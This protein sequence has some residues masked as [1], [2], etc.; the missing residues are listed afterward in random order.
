[1][2][3]PKIATNAWMREKAHASTGARHAR[4]SAFLPL[5]C[6]FLADTPAWGQEGELNSNFLRHGGR[7][8][9]EGGRLSH[10][11]QNN[12]KDFSQWNHMV[13]EKKMETR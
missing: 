5:F 3:G 10:F 6:D 12:L 11:S 13:I 9:G 7:E 2:P 1:M 4:G 8:G